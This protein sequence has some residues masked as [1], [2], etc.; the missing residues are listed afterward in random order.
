MR[1]I[2]NKGEDAA[3]KHLKRLGYTIV[4]RNYFARVGEIDIIAQKDEYL[5]FVEVKMRRSEAYGGGVAAVD[6]HKQQKIRKAAALYLQQKEMEVAVRFD[7]V[8]IHSDGRHIA[9]RDI[10]VIENAF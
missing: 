7:V 9:E 4:E 8:I 3:V 5:V 2:G 6:Y 10:E 1:A